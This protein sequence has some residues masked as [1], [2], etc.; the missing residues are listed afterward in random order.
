MAGSGH[1]D[2]AVSVTAQILRT[3]YLADRN[4]SSEARHLIQQLLTDVHFL[5][6]IG[7]STY[8]RV[9]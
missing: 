8:V 2:E 5:A 3:H 6:P 1:E 9:G 4:W 7:K